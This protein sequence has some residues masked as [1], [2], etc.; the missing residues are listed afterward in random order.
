MIRDERLQENRGFACEIAIEVLAIESHGR[1]RR[2][3]LQKSVVPNPGRAS[4][5][6]DE[7]TVQ[8]EHL[9]GGQVPNHL[10]RSL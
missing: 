6:L 3:G 5:S 10:A 1:P 4:E 8:V 9:L 7:M 2:G